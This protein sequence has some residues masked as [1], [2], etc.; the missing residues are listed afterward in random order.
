MCGL[1]EGCEE[2]AAGVEGVDLECVWIG[3]GGGVDLRAGR[4]VGLGVERAED[5]WAR[6]D[7]GGGLEVVGGE[8][9]WMVVVWLMWS[10]VM[11]TN[12]SVSGSTG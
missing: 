1:V 4:G 9:L 3:G 7:G 2:V 11:G 10:M 5:L 6:M 8:G 12:S